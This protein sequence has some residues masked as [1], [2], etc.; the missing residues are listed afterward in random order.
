MKTLAHSFLFSLTF[1]AAL[2]T[3]SFSEAKPIDRPTEAATYQAGVYVASDSKL[4]VA[5]DKHAGGHV[6]L[7]LR[8]TK[9]ALLYD[10]YLGKKAY[11]YRT[12]LNL[13][14]LPDGTY[15]LEVSNGVETKSQTVTIATQRTALSARLIQTSDVAVR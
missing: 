3:G 7:R 5:V 13:E 10:D 6:T 12:K 9:G 15:Q 4:H 11:K 2:S 1:A 8:D 14:N